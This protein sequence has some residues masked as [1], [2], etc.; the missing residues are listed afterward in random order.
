MKF[1]SAP[2]LFLLIYSSVL[3]AQDKI[4]ERG[5]FT[6]P[7][8]TS[9]GVVFT[10]NYASS[11]YLLKDDKIQTLISSPNCGRYFTINKNGSL[12]GYK[13][14]NESGEQI[15]AVY[16]LADNKT[17]RLAEAQ[18]LAGQ[19]SFADDDAIAFTLGSKLIVLKRELV[20]QFEL[21]SYSNIAP[22]SPDGKY[23]AFNDQTD[24]IFILN[25]QT[26]RKIKVSDDRFGYFNPVWS[27]DSKYLLYS[28]LGG[29][30][31]IYNLEERKNIIVGEGF[32]PSWANNSSSVIFYKKYV[33]EMK[34]VNTDLFIYNAEDEKVV[35][36]TNTPEV[37]EMD[38][39]FSPDDKQIIYHTYNQNKIISAKYFSSE[40]KLTS[41][42]LIYSTS[43]V[44]PQYFKISNS[45]EKITAL[46]IPYVHQVYDTPD[47]HNG[48][49]SCAPT[50]ASMV[51]AYYKL[52]PRWEGWCSWPSPGHTNQWGRY[53]AEKYRFKE[54]Y[55]QASS[56]DPNGSE[57][58]GGFGYM[59][60]A[61]SPHTRM[62]SYYQKHGLN[63]VQ[64]EA[65]PYSEAKAEVEAGY[66]YTMCVM[67]TTAGHLIVAQGLHTER[68]L[69][70]NDPYGNKNT[71]N[72]PSYDGKDVKYDWPGYNN[73][74]Q[75]L[76]GVAWC[77]KH[78][79]DNHAVQDS[80]VDDMEFEDGFYLNTKAPAS[81]SKWNDK[82]QGYKN[83]FWF[84]YT[85]SSG[86]K[87]TC[88]AIW[89][90]TLAQSGYYEVSA[91]IPFSNASDA[92]YKILHNEG[93]DTVIIRQKDFNNEWVSLGSYNFNAGGGMVRLGDA[94]ST[95]AEEI[96]FDAVKWSCLGPLVTVAEEK[97]IPA[98]FELLQNYPNPFNPA[99]K[100]YY[101]VPFN[102]THG[103]ASQQSVLLKV[104]DAIGNE[105][106]TLVNETKAPGSYEI[107]FTSTGGGYNLASGVYFYS[108]RAG[109]YYSVKKMI[110]MR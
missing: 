21:G 91:Y 12:I 73:G 81:M 30:I 36:L 71:P 2:F 54:Y 60:S 37:N 31:I 29:Q 76:T 32:S 49:W 44:Q 33:K 103:G 47:W 74:F 5:Y 94:S 1:V 18:S 84:A 101:S 48:H 53:V 92:R 55:Y 100:I 62:A 99:T 63:S 66:P 57:T 26:K 64:S 59:W 75:N 108:L 6:N 25:L 50:A 10:D 83:H 52:L 87:D 82:N 17:I 27:P 61:G 106:A 88:Y 3:I 22:I 7:S 4:E 65:P 89:R 19:P 67:L 68:T 13:I 80:I 78:R 109:D 40:Q 34:L 43:T 24:Q 70:F 85:N 46:N 90:P 45:I 96:V 39:A 14:I 102:E 77:I 42:K 51:L 98:K 86:I 104:Y 41:H 28:S 23:A 105:V 95:A 20:K 97:N 56:G 110:L 93:Q 11:I 16:K 38:P 79:Y 72:Y 58:W 9:S 69:I 15:P 8:F 107:E 35:R